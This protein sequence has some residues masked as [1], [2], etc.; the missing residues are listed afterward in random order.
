[1]GIDTI[2]KDGESERGLLRSVVSGRA[3]E[4][5]ECRWCGNNYGII[6]KVKREPGTTEMIFQVERASL[7]VSA[8]S[9]DAV[10]FGFSREMMVEYEITVRKGPSVDA[11]V[12]PADEYDA[13]ERGERFLQLERFLSKGT[14]YEVVEDEVPPGEYYFVVLNTNSEDV[15][16]EWQVTGT[17][18]VE[19]I[20]SEE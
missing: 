16:I 18:V 11:T 3:K 20:S 13:I 4:N 10:G 19:D 17:A 15:T 14:V 6:Y 8:Q 2:T 7:K 5:A 9:S 1:V 12:V